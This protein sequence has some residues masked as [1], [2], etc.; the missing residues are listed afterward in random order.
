[1]R[2]KANSNG[3]RLTPP[4]PN[5]P[6]MRGEGLLASRASRGSSCLH[7]QQL[8]GVAV[9]DLGLI[10]RAE[11]NAIHPLRAGFIFHIGLVHRE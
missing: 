4:P 5:L 8:L 6:P 1:M 2:L 9:V 10:V 11:R 3:Y 7:F